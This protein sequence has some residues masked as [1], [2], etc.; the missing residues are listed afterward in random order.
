[1]KIDIGEEIRGFNIQ[2]QSRDI[3]GRFPLH[4]A[5]ADAN[6]PNG[7][8]NQLI[9][10]YPTA[11]FERD[12]DGLC[13][14]FY[15]LKT[16][17]SSFI[18]SILIMPPLAT[19]NTNKFGD[20]ALHTCFQFENDICIVEKLMLMCPEKIKKQN[21][22]F[23]TPIFVL[24]DPTK[25]VTWT[26]HE[27]TQILTYIID[28]EPQILHDVEIH[29]Y[30]P[31]HLAVM[32]NETDFA[33]IMIDKGAN[34]DCLSALGET[35]LYFAAESGLQECVRIL[36]DANCNVNMGN[37][38]LKSPLVA[39]SFARQPGCAGCLKQLISAGGCLPV[40][41]TTNATTLLEDILQNART[42][43]QTKYDCICALMHSGL[44]IDTRP[45]D[46]DTYTSLEY[47]IESLYEIRKTRPGH[48]DAF[49]CFN[50]IS[51]FI[52]QGAGLRQVHMITY[53][54]IG[55]IV[56]L[57]TRETQGLLDDVVELFL[58]KNRC[59][60]LFAYKDIN[61]FN[62]L[63]YAVQQEYSSVVCIILE[64][65]HEVGCITQMLDEFNYN[66]TVLSEAVYS[67]NVK[68]V[69]M[70]LDYGADIERGTPD[71]SPLSVACW[72]GHH[73]IVSL[74]LMRGC[75]TDNSSLVD[76]RTA[77]HVA[78]DN[79]VRDERLL[80][81]YTLHKRGCSWTKAD[82]K[83]ITPLQRAEND[84]EIY[85]IYINSCLPESFSGARPEM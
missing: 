24:L 6:T 70:L 29:G 23:Y 39:A 21:N 43:M 13:P 81:V 58:L 55:Y 11:L 56:Y 77:L 45:N 72:M 38:V 64:H 7:I 47:A 8:I 31:L 85:S 4:R 40:Q 80:C 33:R 66:R 3:H 83:G 51:K 65:M 46:S 1:M 73:S 62:F 30:S 5:M 25:T 32:N 76:G 61:D 44:D 27:K 12:I 82:N 15:T 22:D 9:I 2:A 26:I 20:T 54:V 75:D 16:K 67:K 53:T 60:D 71:M 19:M 49:W 74:L 17:N 14:F 68:L 41:Y 28:C 48:D 36:I 10:E 50:I 35:P 52:D 18:L 59:K 37:T 34:V 42:H 84:P 69:N 63:N 78:L 79:P 57:Y